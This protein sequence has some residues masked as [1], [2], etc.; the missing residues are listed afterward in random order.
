MLTIGCAQTDATS[1]LNHC[2]PVPQAVSPTAPNYPIIETT[3][4]VAGD[5]LLE[6]VVSEAGI[7]IDL[8][9]ISTDSEPHSP[10]YEAAFSRAFIKA[11]SDR[12]YDTRSH[13][14]IVKERFSY[15]LVE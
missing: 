9:V 14:C 5:V 10:A 11:V 3:R 13:A 1:E 6:F 12:R 15:E 7:P 4:P 2:S 8:N